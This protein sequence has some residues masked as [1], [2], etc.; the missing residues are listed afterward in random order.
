MNRLSFF[1]FVFCIHLSHFDSCFNALI[2]LAPQVFDIVNRE[3]FKQSLG[4]N[5]TGIR[6]N[7]LQ[8]GIGLGISIFLSL[9]PSNQGDLSVD[10]WVNQNVESGILP[11]DSHD[12]VKLAEEK[13][14]I[15]RKRGGY[16]NPLT[17]EIYL[18][19]VFHE[20][21]Y[22]RAKNKPI[23]TGTRVSGLPMR[24]GSGLLGHFCLSL[25]HRIFSNKVHVELENAV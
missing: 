9:I 8:L 5:V 13:D 11:L 22:G 24:D 18:Q 16:P 17:Y 6:E 19:Q 21:L 15:L 2:L 3:A 20:Y 1:L 25:A 23:S 12:G 10:S 7:Y 14:D 4:V